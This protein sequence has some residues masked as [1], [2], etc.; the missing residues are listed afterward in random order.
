MPKPFDAVQWRLLILL[1]I[2]IG[3]W[4]TD[5]WHGISPAWVALGLAAILLVPAFGMLDAAAMKTKID[6]SPALFLAAVFAISAV[7]QSTGLG[8]AV[9]RTLTPLLGL[10]SGGGLRDLYAVTGLSVLL[11]HLTTAPAAPAV[12]VPLAAAFATETGWSVETVAMAQVIGISTPI[13]PY[14]APPLIVAMALASIPMAALLRVC[15]VLA[16]VVAVVGLPV[17]YVWWTWL[18]MF[19]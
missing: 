19:Q 9:A 3:F 15:A 8:T 13:L 2:A 17:T 4:V 1:G 10:G 16:L 18:G 14:Q 7:A 11:S 5:T 6:L 12:L